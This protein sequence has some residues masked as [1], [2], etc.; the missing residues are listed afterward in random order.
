MI[1][2]AL[3]VSGGGSKGAFAVG[4]V[5]VLKDHFDI[6]AIAGTSTGA[7]IAPMV[8]ISDYGRLAEIYTMVTNKDILR[9]NWR[10]LF[11]DCM[12]DT[13]PL[14]KLVRQTLDEDNRYERIMDSDKE[15]I[16]CSVSFQTK[17][18]NYYSQ[19][20]KTP[21]TIAWKDKDEMVQCILAST[22][23][24]V[25]MPLV[26]IRGEQHADGG[27][28]EVAPISILEST[29]IRR[30]IAIINHPEEVEPVTSEY[31]FLLKTGIRAL[32]LMS[33]EISHGDVKQTLDYHDLLWYVEDVKERAAQ[34]LTVQ[35]LK[36]VFGP[37][38]P[39]GE[40]LDIT[41]IR[42]EKSLPSDGLDFDP[43][44][45]QKMRHLGQE[46]ARKAMI[47]GSKRK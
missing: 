27:V 21:G 36:E 38:E 8:S 13:K 1:R 35:Q 37:D 47:S 39:E 10:R 22:N 17:R 9:L 23:Q 34:H 6:A 43:V 16:L 33:S 26:E 46:A 4:A 42:P 40:A 5:E 30:V 29:G 14:E 12:Y 7:L 25:Y 41:V 24:P 3:S 20:G 2:V 15:I 45:M 32:D 11:W 44:V 18:I 19:H 28:R 31:G